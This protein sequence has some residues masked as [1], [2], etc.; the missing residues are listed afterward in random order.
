MMRLAWRGLLAVFV[1]AITTNI[2]TALEDKYFDS[3]GVNIRYIEEGTGEP[4]ILLH[5]VTGD[6][7]RWI[8]TGILDQLAKKYHVIAFDSRGHGKSG[9][10]HDPA[11]YGP[12]M[13]QDVIRLMDYLKLPRA[14]IMGYSMGAQIIAQLV[15]KRPERFLTMTLGGHGGLVGW[16]DQD[17]KRVDTES[18]EL[19]QGAITLLL[20]RLWPTDQPKPSAAELQALSA[21]QLEGKDAQAL[22]AYRRSNPKQV[23]SLADMVAIKVP[24]LGIAGTADP[25]KGELEDLKAALPTMRLIL[26]EGASH[27]NAPGRPE[28]VEAVEDFLREHPNSTD[29]R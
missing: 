17:Q 20:L 27:G 15:T 2:T 6:V 4:I 7:T 5:G 19:D 3:A 16:T 10:P 28:Y 11:Q 1:I 9:K 22:A 21:K 29:G 24:T 26:I 23:V 12:E 14:H 8:D 18:S 25:Y 13:G